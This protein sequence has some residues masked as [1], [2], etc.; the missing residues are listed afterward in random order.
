MPDVKI[1]ELPSTSELHGADQIIVEQSDGTKRAELGVLPS[2]LTAGT[3]IDI[4]NSVITNTIFN[5]N[6][7]QKSGIDLNTITEG[8]IVT[9]AL[10]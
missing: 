5:A 9:E 3:G 8:G 4:T 2:I 10:H 7:N 1:T 6:L